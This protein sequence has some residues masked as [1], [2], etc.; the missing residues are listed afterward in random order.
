MSEGRGTVVLA[1]IVA[2]AAWAATSKPVLRPI[3]GQRPQI[4][5]QN[6][7]QDSIQRDHAAKSMPPGLENDAGQKDS[8]KGSHNASEIT[9]LGVKP[10]EW[11]LVVATFALWYATMRLVWDARETSKRQLR[12]YVTVKAVEMEQGAWHYR[13]S[14]D[15]AKHW[16]DPHSK[17]AS[18]CELD[19]ISQWNP[20]RVQIFGF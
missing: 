19:S 7:A 12:A 1:A 2:L 20:K 3:V 5:A 18:S 15:P 10:G 6:Q 9:F 14:S 8:E 17:Y 16:P 13:V 4:G 11:L